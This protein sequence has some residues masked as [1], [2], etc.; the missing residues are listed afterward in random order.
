MMF[1]IKKLICF[2]FTWREKAHLKVFVDKSAIFKV[3]YKSL[4]FSTCYCFGARPDVE[5]KTLLYME[6]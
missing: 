4:W 5:Y 6:V 3:Q 1:K 2:I